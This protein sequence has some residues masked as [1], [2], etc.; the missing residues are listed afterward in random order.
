MSSSLELLE[1]IKSHWNVH[2]KLFEKMMK[3]WLENEW[4][5]KRERRREKIEIEKDLSE[6]RDYW[7]WVKAIQGTFRELILL[8]FFRKAEKVSYW[9]QSSGI[10]IVKTYPMDKGTPQT[11]IKL[12]HTQ[13]LPISLSL[14]ITSKILRQRNGKKK[15]EELLIFHS[16]ASSQKTLSF[17][18]KEKIDLSANSFCTFLFFK[19]WVDSL[20]EWVAYESFCLT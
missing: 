4:E 6:V 2:T 12:S 20:T 1:G 13:T 9:Q 3:V 16:F 11:W 5:V 14:W 7:S 10:D 18:L 17:P 15:E 8:Y 19:R